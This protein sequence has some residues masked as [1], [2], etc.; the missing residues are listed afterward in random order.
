MT[1]D[2]VYTSVHPSI[3][4]ETALRSRKEPALCKSTRGAPSHEQ[5]Q[6]RSSEKPRR[7]VFANGAG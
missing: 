3:C 4:T 6:L 2:I 5:K 7:G 1:Q